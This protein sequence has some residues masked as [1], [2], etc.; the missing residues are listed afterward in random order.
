MTWRTL[1]YVLNLLLFVLPFLDRALVAQ[2]TEDPAPTASELAEKLKAIE[3]DPALGAELKTNLVEAYKKALEHVKAAETFGSRVEELDAAVRAAPTR[4]AEIKEKLAKPTTEVEIDVPVDASLQ[5]LEQLLAQKEAEFKAAQEALSEVI[6]EQEERVKKRGA[7]PRLLTAARERLAEVTTQLGT[8]AA[9]GEAAELSLAKRTVLLAQRGALEREILAYQNEVPS[10]DARAELIQLRRS[11]AERDLA[12]TERLVKSWRDLVV[13][14]RRVESESAERTAREA[15]E[16]AQ[17]EHPAVKLLAEENSRLAEERGRLN[18]LRAKATTQLDDARELLRKTRETFRGLSRKV[19]ASR[20]TSTLG[21][22]LRTQQKKLRDIRELE[23]SISERADEAGRVEVWLVDLEEQR[24][25][26]VDD[27]VRELFERSETPLESASDDLKTRLAELVEDSRLNYVI[28]LA[29]DYENYANK[30]SDLDTEER[31][32]G[33]E[34]RRFSEFIARRI[35]WSRS[36]S[37]LEPA[38]AKK[39]LHAIAWCLDRDHWIELGGAIRESW[40]ERPTPFILFAL[41]LVFSAVVYRTLVKRLRM[42]GEL[43]QRSRS[44]DLSPTLK[45]FFITLILTLLLPTSFWLLGWCCSVAGESSALGAAL[46]TACLATGSVLFTIEIL[47]HTTRDGGLAE[48]HFRWSALTV[49]VIRKN[50]ALLSIFLLPLLFVAA[51]LEGQRVEE[52]KESL[53]RL[54]FVGV[55]V[56]FTFFLARVLSP[57]RGVWHHTI[58]VRPGSLV[59]RF[60]LLWYGGAILAPIALIVLAVLGYYYTSIQLAWRLEVTLWLLLLLVLLQALLLRWLL[61]AKRKLAIEQARS[62]RKAESEQRAKEGAGGAAVS[63]EAPIPL[64]EPTVDLTEVDAQTTRLLRA[65]TLGAFLIGLWVVWVDVLPALGI[66]NDVPLGWTKSVNVYETV[67]EENSLGEE[68]AVERLVAKEI[69]VTAAHLG[70]ALVIGLVAL[71]AARNLPGFLQIALLQRLPLDSGARYAVTAVSG[72]TIT[73]VGI[74]AAFA[75]MGVGWSKVQ[76]LAA[77]LTV[78]LGFGLQEIFANFVSGLIIFFERP[79]RIGD[80]V[81]ID[82]VTGTVTRIQ[83]RATTVTDWDRKE[84]VVPNKDFITGR[85]LNWTLSNSTNRALITVGAA[86]GSDVERAL[87]I[88]KQVA[89]DNPNVLDDPEPISTFEQF[90]DSTLNLVLRCYLPNLDVR[91]ATISELHKAIDREFRAAG[92]EIAFPQRDIHIRG[93]EGSARNSEETLSSEYAPDSVSGAASHRKA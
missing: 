39:S 12:D 89:L 65:A 64:E 44:S 20:F 46:S 17:N 33:A 42:L 51:L 11:E 55:L 87:A 45:A 59:S 8:P 88:L 2:E 85:L 53:G 74:A 52:H 16:A 62:K 49:H 78:G 31:E 9:A 40:S 84:F 7:I 14:R 92:I 10:Y 26:T 75:V 23:A 5:Q 13:E 61:L 70:L 82:N 3:E 71:V 15:A 69:P 28:P 34:V 35:L 66:L 32:L 73:L 48:K 60:R 36:A 81:T 68:T 83:I 90:G 76:W 72:Y 37:A 77:A 27:R 29:A 4:L 91:V 86:Y 6:S 25:A 63:E 50:T 79:V 93:P 30:L 18:G 41:S 80:V 47:R 38:D 22:L 58:R 54:A 21:V 1:P 43:A 24:R 67:L 56:V 57:E 19:D